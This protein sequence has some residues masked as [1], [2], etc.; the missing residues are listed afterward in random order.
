MAHEL[1]K[2][3]GLSNVI[4]SLHHRDAL[5]TQARRF[6]IPIHALV[7]PESCLTYCSLSYVLMESLQII[8][9]TPGSRPLEESDLTYGK[10]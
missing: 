2:V 7:R 9:S 6:G 5:E 8:M 4:F 3:N 1:T 10:T